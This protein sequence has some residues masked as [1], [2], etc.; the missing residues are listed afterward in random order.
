MIHQLVADTSR[1]RLDQLLAPHG[2]VAVSVAGRLVISRAPG[3]VVVGRV[4][5]LRGQPIAGARI[6][7]AGSGPASTIC[8]ESG[9]FVLSVPTRAGPLIVEASSPGYM[10]LRFE[11]ASG[12]AAPVIVR[13]DG[14]PHKVE[15]ITVVDESVLHPRHRGLSVHAVDAPRVN[16]DPI[17]ELANLSGVSDFDA[18]DGSDLAARRAERRSRNRRR[19]SGAACALSPRGL[20]LGPQHRSRLHS[21]ERRRESWCIRSAVRVASERRRRPAYRAGRNRSQREF[22]DRSLLRLGCD[23]RESRRRQDVLCGLGPTRNARS[24]RKAGWP[25]RAAQLLGCVCEAG[26]LGQRAPPTPSWTPAV[27]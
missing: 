15:Q 3:P 4:V 1:G 22:R 12:S 20:W 5:D 8:G 2:L 14:L 16:P 9:E 10:P 17:A 11:V 23:R 6:E 26:D 18:D 13:L 27:G 25:R 7:L 24:G 21:L 19:W